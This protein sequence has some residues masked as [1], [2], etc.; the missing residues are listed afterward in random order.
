MEQTTILPVLNG[1]RILDLTH[2]IAGPYCTKLLADYGADVIKIE[3]PGSGDYA[4]TMGP[5]PDD[6][7][8]PEK[9]G[10]F[11]FLNTNKRGITLDLKSSDGI[12]AFKELVS[13]TDIV[14]ESF[15][16]G[17]MESLGFGYDTLIKI[18]P[19][20]IMTSIS[21]FGQTGPYKDYKAS[22]LILFAMGGKLGSSGLPDRYP[23]K[24]GGNHVQYQ[25]GN[26]A[27]MATLFAWYGKQYGEIGGQH[28]DVSIFETQMASIN[29]RLGSLVQYQY[30]GGL[31]K[32]TQPGS[33]GYPMGY[34]KCKDGYVQVN[35]GGVRGWPL[36]VKMLGLPSLENDP[37]FA[38]PDG[39][40][41]PGSKEEFERT[42]WKP[43]LMER[44]ANQVMEECQKYEIFAVAVSTVDQVMNNNPQ[45][46]FRGF[47]VDIDHPQ[48]G[49]L[50]YPGAPI[51]NNNGWWQP[52]KPAPLLG[53]HNQAILEAQP[54][55]GEKDASQNHWIN[56]PELPQ[57]AST[58]TGVP[59]R[60]GNIKPKLPLEGIR[61]IDVTLYFAGPYATMFLGDLGAEVIRVEPRHFIPTG[62]RGS[63]AFPT[64]EAEEKAATSQYPNRDP[65]ERPWN[66]GA[67]R[68]DYLRNKYSITSDM[69]SP[70]GKEIFRKLAESSDVLVVNLVPGSMER[71]GLTYDVLSKWNPKLIMIA[72][73][74]CGETG[75]WNW[76]RGTGNFFEALFGHASVMG[77]PDMGPDGSPGGVASDACT[78]V[79]NAIAAI[80]GLHQREKTGK[81]MFI[82]IS[83][84]ENFIPHLAELFMDY[85]INGRIAGPQGNR[86]HLGN[87]VQGTYQ[88]N[89]DDDWI[90]ISIARIEEWHSLARL[91]D[92]PE[93]IED[94]RFEDMG[95]LLAHHDQIDNIIEGWT[96]T[97]NSIQLFHLL[98]A[99][100]I[101]GGPILNE[102][103][104]F[105]DPHLIERD[106]FVE[107]D[108][109]EVGTHFYP[110]TT[111]KMSKVPLVVKK[112]PV[113]LG[114][115][116]DWVYKDLLKLT[117]EEYQHLKDIGQIGL[118]MLPSAFK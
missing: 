91:M 71:L 20:I 65:G 22:E 61:I 63:S 9:S 18:N 49:K 83:M 115:D 30:N 8:H 70:E 93:L 82:D 42:I 39:Q 6:T 73:S 57:S 1:I 12:H 69:S 52:L 60:N 74:G 102:E 48:A 92:R 41:N 38:P 35:G 55:T 16:P 53:E 64:K 87:M 72:S 7:P 105:Q 88:C 23:V 76:L 109:P 3:R 32:R 25:A 31:S 99:N 66:R 56:D 95:A 116:N 26:N 103:M 4:R 28:V 75:P 54:S 24:A 117:D 114:E 50:R 17:V 40:L 111:F 94:T 113:R 47:F 27:A 51:Y 112:P 80:M 2:G 14:V 5:F 62:G 101:A 29:G 36:T 84:G 43:W 85:S 110:G 106:F 13:E 107:I 79:T 10:L 15:R 86:D 11:L 77:Y 118:D 33:R 59:P 81:G 98:Q 97:Q 89:G 45:F 44:T 104:A 68:N 108:A 58:K 96:S 34:Y 67:G 78:G 37:R 19:N 100:G 46:D 21:N 90:A